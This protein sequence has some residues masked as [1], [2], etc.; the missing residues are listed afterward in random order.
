MLFAKKTIISNDDV[1]VARG[2]V[3]EEVRPG[4]GFETGNFVKEGLK[5]LP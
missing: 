2:T 3:C 4:A 1:R 5:G